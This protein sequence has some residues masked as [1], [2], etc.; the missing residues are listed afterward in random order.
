MD[1]SKMTVARLKEELDA[2]GLSTTGKNCTRGSSKHSTGPTT[3][4]TTRRRRR[5]RRTRTWDRTIR[6]GTIRD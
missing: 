3:T 5:R 1:P 4:T 2:L 6:S